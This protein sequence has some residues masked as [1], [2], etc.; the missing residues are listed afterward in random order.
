VP[1]TVRPNPPRLRLVR[2][3]AIAHEDG[4]VG[5]VFEEVAV[6]AG[7]DWVE[8]RIHRD[9]APPEDS[10]GAALVFGGTMNTHEEADHPWLRDEDRNIRRLVGEGIPL[11]GV[12]LGG[13]LVAKALDATV[14]ES[15]VPEIGWHDVV[16]AAEATEDPVFAALP[17]EFPSFQWHFYSFDAPAGAVRLARTPVSLQ[18]FRFGDRV[19]AVQFHPEVTR[20]I[21]QDWIDRAEASG[22]ELDYRTLERE[23]DDLIGGWNRIGRELAAGFFAV[24]ER[25]SGREQARTA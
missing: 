25:L 2:V 8:W 6:S 7:H 13:Q 21:L 3:L 9:Q 11:F 14:A 22:L 12:C 4:S 10:F 15:P 18:A 5:G 19:W 16:L 20:E 17:R 24:A 23:C 1:S